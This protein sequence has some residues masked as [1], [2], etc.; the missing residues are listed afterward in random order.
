M[1]YEVT[2]HVKRRKKH[3]SGFMRILIVVMAVVCFLLG[4]IKDGSFV[5]VS[6]NS[7]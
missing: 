7:F 1:A 5:R 6:R 2:T 3:F 4:R